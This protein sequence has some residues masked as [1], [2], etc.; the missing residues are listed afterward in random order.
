M[1]SDELMRQ[2]GS[3]R[4]SRQSA[5][6][7]TA[8]SRLVKA[9]L[10]GNPSDFDPLLC[11]VIEF[12]P[13]GFNASE[14]GA[15]V[16]AYRAAHSNGGNIC[17]YL[18]SDH[19]ATL[20]I[21]Q[22]SREPAEPLSA[23][24]GDV[25]K[26]LNRAAKQRLERA[27]SDVLQSP[28]KAFQ[29]YQQLQKAEPVKVDSLPAILDAAEFLAQ[30]LTTPPE[31]VSGMIHQ[32]SKIG[33]GGGSKSFKTWQLLDLAVS[34]AYGK[35]WLGR[36][37]RTGRVLYVNFEIQP[38]FFQSRLQAVA[39]EKGVAI[40]SGQL[41]VWN[42][43]GKAGDFS[44]LLP[45][46]YDAVKRDFALIILD[47]IY[48]LYGGF[49]DEN[50]AR[51]IAALLNAI[52]DL[53]VST[54]AAVAFGAHFSKG[55]QAA[56]E[57]IDRISGSGVF[58]RDPDSL[59]MFTRHEK[60]DAFTVEAALRNFP[61]VPPFVVRWQFPLMAPDESLDPSK[62]K[63]PGG[64]SREHHPAELCAAIPNTSPENPISISAWAIA[65]GVAR[66]TLTDYLPE[67]RGKGWAATVGKGN[68]ARQY[69]TAKGREMLLS[70]NP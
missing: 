10:H 70:R 8:E 27:A 46:I 5:A 65:A 42:L 34:V 4:V 21:Y 64:R 68:K 37:T 25:Q 53:A 58:A 17:A 31:L 32:G 44:I 13:D 1:P 7:A 18:E 41:S 29:I 2:E 15:I 45:K 60:D 69:L 28:S 57:S 14:C 12:A 23:I 20:A 16:A 61:P 55:N 52:E 63:R 6:D 54:G 26:L 35:E 62:L 33:I 51:D 3:G 19:A 67:I 38:R 49:T 59:L 39:T 30:G 24:A 47:P 48:K 36:K 9:V 40:N 56:K 66:Q 50:N 11:K 22:N 43:R